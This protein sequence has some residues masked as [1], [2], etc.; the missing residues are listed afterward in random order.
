MKIT[1]STG[2]FEGICEH[3]LNISFGLGFF[4]CEETGENCNV[5]PIKR[6]LLEEEFQH[7]KESPLDLLP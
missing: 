4:I 7:A 5:E 2:D 1:G 3:E 6:N